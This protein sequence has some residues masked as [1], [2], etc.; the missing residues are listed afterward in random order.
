M[1]HGEIPVDVAVP[2]AGRGF[3]TDVQ[4]LETV[5]HAFGDIE[6]GRQWPD[7]AAF[8]NQ[9]TGLVAEL[10]LAERVLLAGEA[11]FMHQPVMTATK[12]DQVVETGLATAAPVLNVVAIDEMAV[13]AARKPAE[14]VPGAQGTSHCRGNDP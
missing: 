11:A 6:I 1:P 10:H 14:T 4:L 9:F 8:G 7:V 12:L 3:R 13:G 2:L 5:L